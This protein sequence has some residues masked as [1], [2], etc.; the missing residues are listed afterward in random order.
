MSSGCEI[1]VKV[2]EVVD[3]LRFDGSFAGALQKVVTRKLAVQEAKKRGIKV[4]DGEL[5]NAADI[6]RRVNNL[7]TADQT[8]KWLKERGLS[9][10]TL[11]EY[12]ET[13]LLIHELK[14][15]LEKE[16]DREKYLATRA[17]KNSIRELAYTEWL[18][19]AA[20]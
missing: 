2:A 10:E 11:E 12:L 18:S 13:N 16:Y 17:A 4:T 1:Q 6:F 15:Q 5:Q 19:G 3:Y 9:V 7:V 8:D 14:N 20:K